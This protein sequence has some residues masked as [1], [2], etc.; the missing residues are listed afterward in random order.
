VTQDSQYGGT[1]MAGIMIAQLSN[2]V[3]RSGVGW[4]NRMDGDGSELLNTVVGGGSERT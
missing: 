1:S 3:A 4:L 2:I